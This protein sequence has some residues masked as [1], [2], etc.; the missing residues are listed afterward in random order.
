MDKGANI[1]HALCQAYECGVPELHEKLGASFRNELNQ[2][3][4]SD[5][6]V[7][8]EF[9]K[10][11]YAR[12]R[13]DISDNKAVGSIFKAMNAYHPLFS[14]S[15]TIKRGATT[16]KR[17]DYLATTEEYF[18][19][20][21]RILGEEYTGLKG[22]KV[23][24]TA[25]N[26]Y[27]SEPNANWRN[28]NTIEV[29]TDLM[30]ELWDGRDAHN[31][32]RLVDEDGNLLV[33]RINRHHY[34]ILFIRGIKVVYIKFDCRLQA[35]VP[36]SDASHNK[37]KKAT[38]AKRYAANFERIIEKLMRGEWATPNWWRDPAAIKSFEKNLLRLG[39]VKP[40]PSD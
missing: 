19:Q 21:F 16:L 38:M 20:Q 25:M 6:P 39:F 30:L 24:I 11:I 22:D 33:R 1:I 37:M 15:I 34:R 17:L 14:I 35:Q 32:E 12:A 5:K 31:G 23:K 7:S 8:Y 2:L 28:P 36:L 10:R 13:K 18:E 27:I 9:L 3:L 26:K 40:R 29:Q 4:T